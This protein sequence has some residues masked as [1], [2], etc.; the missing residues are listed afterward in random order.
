MSEIG[1]PGVKFMR[2]QSLKNKK[3]GEIRGKGVLEVNLSE[4]WGLAPPG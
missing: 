3:G 1:V 2:N 4:R